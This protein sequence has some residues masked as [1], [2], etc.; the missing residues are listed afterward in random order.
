MSSA[1]PVLRPTRVV[2]LSRSVREVLFEFC[3]HVA[4]QS[5]RSSAVGGDQTGDLALALSRHNTQNS[6]VGCRSASQECVCGKGGRA[7]RRK[8]W[9]WTSRRSRGRTCSTQEGVAVDKQ[10]K[11]RLLAGAAQVLGQGV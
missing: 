3:G 9:L 8:V 2:V 1:D 7:A 6:E 4:Q 11:Q 5:R 10:E